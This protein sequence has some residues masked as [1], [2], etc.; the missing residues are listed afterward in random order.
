MDKTKNVEHKKNKT[1]EG[2]LLKYNRIGQIGFM[3]FFKKI[4]AKIKINKSK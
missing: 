3:F 2:N 1:Q 4:I